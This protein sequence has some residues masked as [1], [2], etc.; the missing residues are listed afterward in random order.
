MSG[1]GGRIVVGVDGSPGAL[2]ALRFALAEA[3][4]RGATLHALLAW[5]LPLF[6]GVPGPFLLEVPGELVPPL[7]QARSTLEAEARR[8][9]DDALE[10]ALAGEEPGVE[11]RRD[12]VEAAPVQ[13]LL[14]AAAG[15][16]LLVLG[17]RGLGGFSGLLLGS[18]SLR[19][20]RSAPC[21]VAIVR[22]GASPGSAP[23]P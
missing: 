18:V 14:A 10:R 2:A 8:A 22:G 21:P 19:C 5:E 7:E 6:E 13:A 15:A 23:V 1:R 12:V 11:I 17:S 9:L 16:D 20:V 4:L 3:R